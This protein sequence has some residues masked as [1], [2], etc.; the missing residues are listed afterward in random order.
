MKKAKELWLDTE[1]KFYYKRLKSLTKSGYKKGEY[2]YVRG[3][4]SRQQ[5]VL[6]EE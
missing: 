1:S 3:G 2:H 6:I 4:S 5:L